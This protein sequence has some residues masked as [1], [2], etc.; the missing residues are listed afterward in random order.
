[1]I[2]IAS[3]VRDAVDADPEAKVP[4]GPAF[5]QAAPVGSGNVLHP[6]APTAAELLAANAD[7][8]DEDDPTPAALPIEP[9][10][11][12]EAGSSAESLFKSG[13]W[14]A[15]VKGRFDDVRVT[16]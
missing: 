11:A 3:L 15:P 13:L 6:E 5:G 8:S 7:N 9:R 14:P 4:K 10:P 2:S 16:P 12:P 1:M